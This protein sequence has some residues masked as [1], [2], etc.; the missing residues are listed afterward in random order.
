MVPTYI[1][2]RSLEREEY[3]RWL[4]VVDAP[5]AQVLT[6][7]EAVDDASAAGRVDDDL[8][9]AQGRRHIQRTDE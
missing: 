7:Q 3:L 6:R 9:A 5:T 4:T 2:R 8:A 1:I